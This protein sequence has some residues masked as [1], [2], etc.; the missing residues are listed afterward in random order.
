MGRVGEKEDGD[1][2][3]DISGA[4][5]RNVRDWMWCEVGSGRDGEKTYESD[6]ALPGRLR[7]PEIVCEPVADEETGHVEVVVDPSSERWLI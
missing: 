1:A 6:R 2:L 3:W 7:Y 5:K 4:E